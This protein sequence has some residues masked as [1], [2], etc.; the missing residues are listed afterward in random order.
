MTATSEMG[1]KKIKRKY[2]GRT[3]TDID[4]TDTG[5]YNVKEEYRK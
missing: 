1:N 2:A 5:K 4:E 3:D